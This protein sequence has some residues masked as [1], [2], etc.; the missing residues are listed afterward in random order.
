MIQK[1]LNLFLVYKNSGK[2]GKG[3]KSSKGIFILAAC[4]LLV[5]L[6]SYGGILFIKINMQNQT[7]N[8]N[9]QLSVPSVIV[10]NTKIALENKKNELLNAYQNTI[11]VAKTKFDTSLIIDGDLLIKIA[12]SMPTDVGTNSM[13]IS[14]LS[15]GMSCSCTE[16]MSPAIFAQNLTL[17]NIFKSVS[18]NGVIF[19]PT[20]NSFA[21]DL[22]CE[23]KEVTAEWVW[24]QEKNFCL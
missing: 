18:Y 13:V 17:K 6:L 20:S 12:S 15:L 11:N 2:G 3:T 7:N 16:K 24:I 19:N 23:F 4:F 14:P 8:I 5:V 21:F 9:N 1:D 22:I 10:A